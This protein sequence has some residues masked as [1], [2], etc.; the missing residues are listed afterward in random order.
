M[1]HRQWIEKLGLSNLFTLT[2]RLEDFE[3][4]IEMWGGFS[5]SCLSYKIELIPMKFIYNSYESPAF[6]RGPKH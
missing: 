2:G 5:I 1:I 6:Q 4:F 3:T